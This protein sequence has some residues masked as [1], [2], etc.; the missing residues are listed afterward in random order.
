MKTE[1]IPYSYIQSVA[2]E[3]FNIL[4]SNLQPHEIKDMKY[5]MTMTNQMTSLTTRKPPSKSSP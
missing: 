3:W 4:T 5:A 1:Y 2:S